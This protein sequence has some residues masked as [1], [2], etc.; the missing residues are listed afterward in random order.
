MGLDR[1]GNKAGVYTYKFTLRPKP[2]ASPSCQQTQGRNWDALQF[3]WAAGFPDGATWMGTASSR[4]AYALAGAG[5][6][7]S[8]DDRCLP[9][10]VHL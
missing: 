2:G 8:G 10:F 9:P 3:P 4:S 6:A 1:T 5:M 7:W